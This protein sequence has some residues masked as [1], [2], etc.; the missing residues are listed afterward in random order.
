[1]PRAARR[2]SLMELRQ[3]N[4][5][6]RTRRGRGNIEESG[7]ARPSLPRADIEAQSDNRRRECTIHMVVVVASW[8]SF[9][10]FCS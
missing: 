5:A 8:S 1:M 6:P 9:C 10:L 3:L 7:A 2:T 4:F